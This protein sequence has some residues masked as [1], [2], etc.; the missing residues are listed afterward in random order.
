VHRLNLA[1]YDCISD[2]WCPSSITMVHDKLQQATRMFSQ[3][4]HQLVSDKIVHTCWG[5]RF[6]LPVWIIRPTHSVRF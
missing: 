4:R 6:T 2:F 3:L 1:I 5:G